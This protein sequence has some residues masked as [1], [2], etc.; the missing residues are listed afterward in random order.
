M[1]CRLRIEG[2][3]AAIDI[4]LDDVEL[5]D[6]RSQSPA[7]S[8]HIDSGGGQRVHQTVSRRRIDKYQQ[9]TGCLWVKN[10]VGKLRLDCGHLNT[11][12]IELAIAREAARTKPS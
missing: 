7:Y 4:P 10:D 5:R 1:S 11:R 12:R 9:A 6:G 3:R 8:R 2:Q